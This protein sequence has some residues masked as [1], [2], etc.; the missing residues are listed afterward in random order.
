MISSISPSGIR[1]GREAAVV[2]PQ[3]TLIRRVQEFVFSHNFFNWMLLGGMTTYLFYATLPPQELRKGV[4]L[5]FVGIPLSPFV[6]KKSTEWFTKFFSSTEVNRLGSKQT[7]QSPVTLVDLTPEHTLEEALSRCSIVGYDAL[8]TLA[9]II[10]YPLGR[11]PF[12]FIASKID[13]EWQFRRIKLQNISREQTSI[14]VKCAL[15]CLRLIA[16]LKFVLERPETHHQLTS[17]GC[18]M[19]L[20]PSNKQLLFAKTVLVLS[21]ISATLHLIGKKLKTRSLLKKDLQPIYNMAKREFDFTRI[22]LDISSSRNQSSDQGLA[23]LVT[24]VR[25][26]QKGT[27]VS[28]TELTDPTDN[29]ESLGNFSALPVELILYMINFCSTAS[30]QRL[31]ATSRAFNILCKE[32][33]YEK[34]KLKEAYPKELI[35]AIGLDRLAAAPLLDLGAELAEPVKVC[36]DRVWDKSLYSTIVHDESFFVPLKAMLEIETFKGMDENFSQIHVEEDGEKIWC[37]DPISP[38]DPWPIVHRKNLTNPHPFLYFIGLQDMGI[39]DL[40][41]FVDPAGRHGIALKLVSTCMFENKK[42]IC[43]GVGILHQ[44]YPGRNEG[45][46]WIENL[47]IT[48]RYYTHKNSFA[49]HP[50]D[51]SITKSRFI[52][53]IMLIHTLKKQRGPECANNLNWLKK[54]VTGHQCGMLYFGKELLNPYIPKFQL[55]SYPKLQGST[56]MKS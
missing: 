45:W 8:T 17:Y 21:A 13:N 24:S 47:P 20:Q 31:K 35:D 7:T 4:F 36:T 16:M 46:V 54:L 22:N 52:R 5:G 42:I 10:T 39:H 38:Y 27:S 50:F 55:G 2:N 43:A 30:V 49:T 28:L 6:Y 23:Q 26:L 29:K 18:S 1:Q 12:I 37:L 51:P 15:V 32:L 40:K 56:F 9:S 14:T 11:N 3:G 48:S 34:Q 33:Y 25:G 53:H 44:I 19:L 41:R